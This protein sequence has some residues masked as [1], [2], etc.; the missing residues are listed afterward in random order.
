MQCRA[1]SLCS[2]FLLSTVVVGCGKDTASTSSAAPSTAAGAVATAQSPSGRQEPPQCSIV[3]LA[4]LESTLGVDG[5]KGPEPRGEW[6]VRACEYSGGSLNLPLATLRFEVISSDADFQLIR[7]NH[8][9]AGQPTKD[10][11]GLGEAAFSAYVGK[12]ASIA[13]LYKKTVVYVTTP[14]APLEKQV[15]LV[16]MVLGRM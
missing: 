15:A 14:R 13:A 1:V 16:R 5:L 11:P 7:K 10:F 2:L 3:S 12:Y 9:G 6:P 8:E 4:E